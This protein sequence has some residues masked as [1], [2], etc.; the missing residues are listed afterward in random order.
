MNVSRSHEVGL[1]EH[2]VVG[3]QM[4]STDLLTGK[5]P[6]NRHEI[7][8]FRGDGGVGWVFSSSE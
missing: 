2:E 1:L 5:R 4:T 6:G 3:Q 8:Y 7:F